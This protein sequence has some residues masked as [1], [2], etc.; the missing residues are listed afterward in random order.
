M[1]TCVPR[2]RVLLFVLPF[3]AAALLAGCNG[4]RPAPPLAPP[5]QVAT[6][7]LSAGGEEIARLDDPRQVADLVSLLPQAER[8]ELV[9]TGSCT[10]DHPAF[11]LA[12]E[13]L[14]VRNPGLPG[15]RSP[16][17]PH[18]IVQRTTWGRIKLQMRHA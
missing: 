4:E 12:L 17:G 11:K 6:L 16:N 5:E 14:L 1:R 15:P 2:P 13:R 9:A 3:L 18:G 7:V 8:D 10:T